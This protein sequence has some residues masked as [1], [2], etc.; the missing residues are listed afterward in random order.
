V[1]LAISTALKAKNTWAETPW[2]DRA[3]VFLKAAALIVSS[4]N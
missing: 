3:A 2:Q 1:Q 4:R